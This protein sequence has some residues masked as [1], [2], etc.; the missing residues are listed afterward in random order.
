MD[1]VGKA[2]LDSNESSNTGRIHFPIRRVAE[3]DAIQL[4]ATTA[5]HRR[6]RVRFRSRQTSEREREREVVSARSIFHLVSPSFLRLCDW[7]SVVRA[8]CGVA[9]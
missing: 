2:I 1:R 3:L 6:G 9:I 5:D 4:V 8:T 7:A